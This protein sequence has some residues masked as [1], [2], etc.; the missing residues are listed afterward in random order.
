MRGVICAGINKQS[1][2]LRAAHV[3]TANVVVWGSNDNLTTRLI[4]GSGIPPV[5]IVTLLFTLHS[6]WLLLVLPPLEEMPQFDA[7]PIPTLE[8]LLLRVAT[9]EL[10]LPRVAVGI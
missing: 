6:W 9:L 2:A 5:P 3:P 1:I 4:G 10:L 8:L 7:M